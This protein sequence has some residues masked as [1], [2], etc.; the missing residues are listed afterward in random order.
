MSDIVINAKSDVGAKEAFIEGLLRRGF[1][2]ARVTGSPADITA[3]R[4]TEV[5]YFEIKYTAQ[6]SL[7]FGAATLTEWEAALA[8]EDRYRFVVATKRDGF[9]TFHEYTPA[10]F[11]E[12]SSI[13]PFKIFFHVAVGQEKATQARR[14]SKRVQLTR[15]RVVQMVELFKRFRSE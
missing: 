15:E 12:F 2:E 8:Y 3:R 11:M 6:D 5:Y 4:G 13:P 14:G 1:D 9:W 10:E 7:Y